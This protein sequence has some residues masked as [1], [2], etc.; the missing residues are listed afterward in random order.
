MIDFATYE[1]KINQS[2]KILIIYGDEVQLPTVAVATSLYL[3]FRDLKKQVFLLSSSIPIVEF[4]NLV[5][6]NKVKNKLPPQNLA[7]TFPYS[8]NKVHEITQ[9]VDL[10]KQVMSLVIHPSG[11]ETPLDP[12]QVNLSYQTG[13]FDLIFLLDVSS[14]ADLDK[15]NHQTKIALDDASKIISWNS[16]ANNCPVPASLTV[17]L[18]KDDNLAG[19]WGQVLKDNQITISPDQ[20]SNLLAGIEQATDRLSRADVKPS[21]FELVAWLLRQGGSRHR[22][23]QAVVDNFRPENHLPKIK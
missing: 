12:S 4:C 17:N 16:F 21:I 23:D 22:A 7:I 20:A 14:Q 19:F 3:W 9:D 15:I 11:S 10:E 1:Q 2:E 6:I 18:T 13:D 8:E 5:G